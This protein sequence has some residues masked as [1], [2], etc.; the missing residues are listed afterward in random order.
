MSRFKFNAAAAEFKLADESPASPAAADAQASP[1]APAAPAP[2]TESDASVA[3]VS[4]KLESTSVSSPAAAPASPAPASPSPAAPARAAVPAPKPTG[5]TTS[6]LDLSGKDEMMDDAEEETTPLPE[7]PKATPGK[8]N[9][10]IVFIGHVDAGKST[11]AGHIMALMGNVDDRT[12]ERYEREAKAKNR[13]SWKYAWVLDA[14][15]EER[16]RGKTV[17]VGQVHFETEK[18]HYTILDAPGHKSFVPHMIGGATQADLAILV[19]SARTGEFESGFDKG[20]QTREHAMLAKTAGVRHL[21]VAVNKMDEVQWGKERYDSIVEKLLPFL[22][23]VGFNPKSD[24]TFIP[25]AG[26]AGLNLTTRLP[27]GVCTWWDGPSLLEIMENL[28]APERLLDAPVRFVVTEKFKDMGGT[29]VMGKLET[30]SIQPGKKLVIYPTKQTCECVGI[31][32]D[33]NEIPAAEPGDNV[34]LR[35]RGAE[36]EDI[37]TGF[38]IGT[39]D[40]VVPSVSKFEA[41]LMLLDCRNIISA[42]YTC[43]MH[44]H[45]AVT[46]CKITTLVATLDKKTKEVKQQKPKFVKT[47][48]TAIVRIELPQTICMESFSTLDKL[49]RFMLR[50]EGKTIGIGVI[51]KLPKSVVGGSA[52]Q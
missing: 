44:I 5:P 29:M 6:H 34:R 12:M 38:V 27:E 37:H 42:G 30:G 21:I 33:M 3:E 49:G 52:A 15:E 50:D 35:I 24:I 48:D 32:I 26:L 28:K 31:F 43:M 22:R 45:S 36:E 40:Y 7:A 46:E 14:N 11:T 51:T 1:V 41:Q 19:I 8:R 4:T 25:I 39:A 16:D 47:G 23:S 9:M 18:I 20:G 13:E 2:A 10:N 17:E